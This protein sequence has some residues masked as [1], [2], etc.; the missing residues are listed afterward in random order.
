MVE[1]NEK[2]LCLEVH[3]RLSWD[4][5]VKFVFEDI[6]QELEDW[7]EN[8]LDDIRENGIVYDASYDDLD[9]CGKFL[10]TVSGM[11]KDWP[12]ELKVTILKNIME[13][14]NAVS[15]ENDCEVSVFDKEIICEGIYQT[16]EK[17]FNFDCRIE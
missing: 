17:E 8:N 15:H 16:I 12:R 3:E 6:R 1:L 4:G 13:H 14:W 2:N 5:S 11:E 9:N 10:D 7:Y